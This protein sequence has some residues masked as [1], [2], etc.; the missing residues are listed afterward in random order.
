MKT[1]TEILNLCRQCVDLLDGFDYRVGKG[2]HSG[3]CEMCRKKGT[4]LLVR[5]DGK[6]THEQRDY[7]YPQN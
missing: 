7:S 3:V 6:A 1:M 2:E 5:I 4:V